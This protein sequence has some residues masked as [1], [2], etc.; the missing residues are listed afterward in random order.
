MLFALFVLVAQGEE[1]A[2]AQKAP[3]V[4]DGLGM[5]FPL[6][7]IFVAFYFLIIL[8][9]QRRERKQREALMASIKKNDEVVTAGGIIGVVQSVKEG[10][11]VVLKIDDNA[12][13]RVLKSSIVRI[14][15]KDN[16]A[17]AAQ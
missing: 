7:A 3:G 8:P 10:D 12:R 6:L 5:L 11:E 17:P 14:L 4:G 15:P 2:P 16:A 9:T 13:M 1:G